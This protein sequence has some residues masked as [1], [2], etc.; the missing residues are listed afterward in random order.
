MNDT[1]DTSIK[2]NLLLIGKTG[3]GKSSFANYLFGVDKFTTG[4]GAPVTKWEENFQ[5]YSLKVYAQSHISSSNNASKKRCFFQFLAKI[6]TKKTAPKDSKLSVAEV[7]IYD[8]VGLEP[9]NFD[10][11]MGE[12]DRF[13]SEKQVISKNKVLPAN[14]IIHVCFYVVNGAGARLEPNELG[15]INRI[16]DKHKIPVSVIITNCDIAAENQM[17]AIENVTRS[18]GTESIRIC[19]VSRKTRSGEKKEPFGKDIALKKVLAASYEKVGKELSIIAYKKLIN[20]FRDVQGKLINKIENSDISIFK[21]D[22]MDS[23]IEKI[24]GELDKVH[25]GFDDIKDFLPPAYYSYY[26][27]IENFDID[28]QGRNIFEESFEEINDFEFDVENMDLARRMEKAMEDIE[29]GGFFDKIGAVINMV[30]FVL[31]IK[32]NLKKAITEMFDDIIAKLNSQLWKIE[33]L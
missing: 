2:C 21:R 6:F 22:E 1:P 18:K 11:W 25:S 8:S 26:D 29:D 30:G 33:R 9:D 4:T 13:L 7:N 32:S 16:C 23:T 24:T 3:A 10:K 14:E 15:I 20:F 31:F 28:F 19:S 5:Q 17:S 12:L 27:F